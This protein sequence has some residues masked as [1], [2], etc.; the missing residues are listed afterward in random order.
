[1]RPSLSSLETEYSL[2]A[3]SY[4]GTRVDQA[5]LIKNFMDVA[6]KPFRYLNDREGGLYLAN[7]ARLYPD[8]GLHPEY[9]CPECAGHPA[10]LVAHL[11][12]GHR[13]VEQLCK[14]LQGQR[15]YK[16][17][18]CYH[19][20]VD[21]F[22]RNTWGCHE[23]YLSQYP[24]EHHKQNLYALLAAR[25]IIIG[26]GGF[27]PKGFGLRFSL[28]PRL[29]LFTLDEA[30]HSTHSRPIIH[31]KQEPHSSAYFRIHL[32]CRE[33][34]NSQIAEKVMT[35]LMRLVI[36]LGDSG[37][38]FTTRVHTQSPLN[39]LFETCRST[40]PGAKGR[41]LTGGEIP[42]A[43][44]PVDTIRCYISVI[45]DHLSVLPDWSEEILT[46]AEWLLAKLEDN[47]DS[48]FGILDWPTKKLMFEM[49]LG[50]K[51]WGQL[52]ADSK[53]I[54]QVADLCNFAARDH[55]PLSLTAENVRDTVAAEHVS[56]CH[57]LLK[58]K[59]G[60]SWLDEFAELRS[61]LLHIDSTFSDV[62]KSTWHELRQAEER[63]VSDSEVDKAMRSPP[64]TTRAKLRGKM[65]HHYSGND[66]YRADWSYIMRRDQVMEMKDPFENRE[67]WT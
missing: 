48:L 51:T 3:Y 41:L 21:Y 57:K 7:G 42:G 12:A 63:V 35:G 39:A 27:A 53:I 29:Q 43:L 37:V 54:D 28:A 58:P 40:N 55:M 44:S 8:A 46:D 14:S 64:E 59:G 65:V 22:T 60:L 6:R 5:A 13:I 56:R 1:M 26:S 38:N 61:R 17:V 20:N 31:T 67:V 24:V 47:P 45:R 4:R 19:S 25:P 32:I 62:G 9:A 10:E 11:Q 52:D 34:I 16:K 15:S 66:Q 30:P 18:L 23:N 49:Q 50:E 36:R 2:A 33:S